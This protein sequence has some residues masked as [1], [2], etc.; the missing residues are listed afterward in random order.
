MEH[1]YWNSHYHFE[2]DQVEHL[3][4]CQKRQDSLDIE[5]TTWMHGNEDKNRNEAL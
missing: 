3:G 4:Y 2:Y 5:Y 1:A